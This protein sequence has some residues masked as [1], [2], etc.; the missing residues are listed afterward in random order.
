MEKKRKPAPKSGSPRSR[1]V[2]FKEV[3]DHPIE[4]D[5]H[6]LSKIKRTSKVSRYKKEHIERIER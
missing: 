2:T 1:K 3:H 6:G 4:M 5:K